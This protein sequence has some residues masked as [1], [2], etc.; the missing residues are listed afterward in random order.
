MITKLAAKSL[1]DRRGS[2]ILTCIALLISV[3]VLLGVE[4]IRKESKNSFSSTIS[5]TD[6]IV[7]ARSGSL[8]LLLYSVFRIGSPVNDISW[9]SYQRIAND[10]RV[11]WTIP[12][13][14][15]DSHRGYRVLGT[16][17]SYF[18]HFSYGKDRLLTF[19]N[20][21]RFESAFEV[22]L[23]AQ[24]AQRLDYSIGQ[25]I[26]LSHGLGDANFANHA[27]LFQI[28]GILDPTGTPV[29]QTV[30]VSL[31]GI[32]A[33][34]AGGESNTDELIPKQTTAVLVG[35][36]SKISTFQLQREV[37]ENQTEALTAIL[38]GVALS[39]LW[40]MMSAFE[41]TLRL[42]SLLVFIAAL[43][44]MCSMMAA[45]IRERSNE[46]H[47]LRTMG[48]SPWF[49]F[50]LFEVEAILITLISVAVAS[51]LLLLTLLSANQFLSSNV[52]LHISPNIFT[53][54]SLAIV[55]AIFIASIIVAAAPAIQANR[56][57][58]F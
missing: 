16:N 37:N 50:I 20:G 40:N 14:L 23:G 13:S 38:P 57:T 31:Q 7:G 17:E 12:L 21:R 10:R 18:Q 11:E 52:G 29:D 27:E 22:V 42:I 49:L 43:L 3:F 45:S 47:L 25:K 41:N 55:L 19:N 1:I 26:T 33:I 30:H 51:G 48:A 8:N 24:V 2:A 53:L 4:H 54:N 58:E 28:V 46:I 36:K 5:G 56:N 9:N 39:E 34:H 32:E 44:G 6:L 35:L 15:G